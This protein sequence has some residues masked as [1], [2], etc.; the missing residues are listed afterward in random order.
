MATKVA[1]NAKK[2]NLLDHNSIKH[3]LDESVTEVTFYSPFYDIIKE[4]ASYI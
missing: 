3:V 1:K 2:A 4:L